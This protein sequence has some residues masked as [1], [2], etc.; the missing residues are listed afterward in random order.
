M[1][2]YYQKQIINNLKQ[3]VKVNEKAK[4]QGKKNLTAPAELSAGNSEIE[5]LQISGD[6]LLF[7]IVGLTNL[8]QQEQYIYQINKSAVK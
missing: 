1:M 2:F 4:L 7:G 5:G 3:I 6:Y 8:Q